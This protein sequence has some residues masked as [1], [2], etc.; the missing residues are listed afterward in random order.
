MA[1]PSCCQ[2]CEG[3]MKEWEIAQKTLSLLRSKVDELHM[4]ENEAIK[5]AQSAQE[6]LCASLGRE[7]E[8]LCLLGKR[9]ILSLRATPHS[10][11]IPLTIHAT[12]AKP[13]RLSQVW[14]S[15]SCI[16]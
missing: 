10:S 15:N 12:S 5:Q 1:T 11:Q 8:L 16:L 14:L 6:Q 7:Q 3:H 9:E 4:R 13:P 2:L